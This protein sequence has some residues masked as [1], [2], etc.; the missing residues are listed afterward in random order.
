MKDN[1]DG[2][3]CDYTK[4]VTCSKDHCYYMGKGD[5]MHTT[6][7]EWMKEKKTDAKS[8]QG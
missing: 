4:A 1:Y 2:G 5:C 6:R 3:V 8:K 7:K